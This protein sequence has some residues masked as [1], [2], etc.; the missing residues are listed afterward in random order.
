MLELS[1]K[2]SKAKKKK[3]FKIEEYPRSKCNKDIDCAGKICHGL[4]GRI[5]A[6]SI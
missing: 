1:V 3:V 2:K 4:R 6:T 5:F